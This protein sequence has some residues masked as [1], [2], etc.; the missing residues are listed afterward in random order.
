MLV[1]LVL[2]N[3]KVQDALHVL[4][5]STGWAELE[6][7]G[8]HFG[9]PAQSHTSLTGSSAVTADVVPWHPRHFTQDGLGQLLHNVI[10]SDF[11]VTF[12]GSIQSFLFSVLQDRDPSAEG[13]MIKVKFRVNTYSSRRIL[14][15]SH[16]LHVGQ[17]NHTD[18]HVMRMYTAQTCK[19]TLS[20]SFSALLTLHT[21]ALP[22]PESDTSG[23]LHEKMGRGV[24]TPN[25]TCSI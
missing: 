13:K 24:K 20:S 19:G 14:L 12:E 6:G 25:C 18:R 3:V 5:F 11:L 1:V 17:A 23:H 10:L 4:P 21:P 7:E 2:E 15:R 9:T 16:H 8:D 22:L